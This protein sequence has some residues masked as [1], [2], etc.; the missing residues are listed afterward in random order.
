MFVNNNFTVLVTDT[1]AAVMPGYYS[2][3]E[4]ESVISL[5]NSTFAVLEN[6]N[7]ITVYY[8]DGVK[9]RKVQ[10]IRSP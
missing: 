1:S 6:Y 5:E 2:T 7:G 8:F 4:F 3:P 9:V 10:K